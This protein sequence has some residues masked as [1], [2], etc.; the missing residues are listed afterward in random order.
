MQQARW[1]GASATVN[2][3]QVTGTG[4]F[5]NSRTGSI[6]L[7]FHG[8]TENIFGTSCTPPGQSS[9]T[10]TT[11]TLPFHL[12]TI[13]NG[14]PAAL[15]TPPASGGYATY[16][17]AGGLIHTQLSGN[18]VI[19]ELTTPEFNEASNTFTVKFSGTGTTQNHKTIDG[20]ST[21]YNLQSSVNGGA[22]APFAT[23]AQMTASFTNGGIAILTYTE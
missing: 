3:T 20:S 23:N 12:V 6:E 4:A 17:C 2:C 15:I 14:E 19:G 10:I 16:S 5:E 1:W 11:A 8:C 13:T 21:E 18:G 22:V 9:G 7:T